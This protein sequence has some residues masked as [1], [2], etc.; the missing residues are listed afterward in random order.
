[1]LL[2]AANLMLSMNFIEAKNQAHYT[3]MEFFCNTFF[4]Q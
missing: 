2:N 4:I 3:I 1:M